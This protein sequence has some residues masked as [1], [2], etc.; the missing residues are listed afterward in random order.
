M[1][2]RWLVV[3]ILACRAPVPEARE[4]GTWHA[5]PELAAIEDRDRLRHAMRAQRDALRDLQASLSAGYLEEGRAL[6]F[7][8]ARADRGEPSAASARVTTAA[9]EIATASSLEQ[10]AFAVPRLVHACAGC[11]GVRRRVGKE[12]ESCFLEE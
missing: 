9:R 6:A 11:H 12:H 10:A 7:L 4:L 1:T 3:A 8:I 2:G 5:V